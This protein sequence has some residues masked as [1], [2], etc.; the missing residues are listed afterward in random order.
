MMRRLD[1]ITDSMDMSLGKLRERVRD[2][3]SLAGY[4]PWRR[5]N[6]SLFL[7]PWGHMGMR[8]NT[9]GSWV[10]PE[11]YAQIPGMESAC[12]GAQSEHGRNSGFSFTDVIKA[13]RQGDLSRAGG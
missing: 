1:G 10:A 6:L 5:N 9:Q 12:I 13:T 3:E 8:L 7:W 2:R 4:S 11:S